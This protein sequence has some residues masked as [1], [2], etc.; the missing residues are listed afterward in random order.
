MLHWD[1]L[2]ALGDV[3]LTL[4]AAAAITAVLMVSRAWRLA[5]WWALAFVLG[6]GLVAASKVLYLGW[7]GGVPAL[8]FK[9]LSGHAA[10]ASAVFPILLYLLLQRASPTLRWAGVAAGVGLGLL[11]TATLVLLCHHS[12]AEAIAGCLVGITASIGAIRIGGAAPALRPLGSAVSFA[13]VFGAGIWLMQWA[14]LGWW[15]IKAARLLSGKEQV[16]SIDFE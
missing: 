5:W 9:A 4:P 2:V 15:M 11:V 14:P 10:G 16:F 13:L 1:R 8:G 7:G 12:R 3:A 6:I